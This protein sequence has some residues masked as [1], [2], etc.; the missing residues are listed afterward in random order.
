MD[1]Q[2]LK[3][4]VPGKV[5]TFLFRDQHHRINWNFVDVEKILVVGKPK[6]IK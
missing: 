6:E 5:I 3:I 4:C 1:C 2:I